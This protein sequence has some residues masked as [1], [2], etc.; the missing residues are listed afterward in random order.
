MKT[1]IL[2]S[3]LLTFMGLLGCKK[4]AENGTV[5]ASKKLV[6][7]WILEKTGE[8]RPIG[9]PEDFENSSTIYEF[10][11]SGTLLIKKGGILVETDKWQVLDEGKLMHYKSNPDVYEVIEK[12]GAG[13]L[14]YHH[15]FYNNGQYNLIRYYFKRQN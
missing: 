6:G 10:Q 12:L 7:T 2:S 14:I 4:E 5:S 1:I 13:E 8:E 9:A 3:I 15:L 11:L